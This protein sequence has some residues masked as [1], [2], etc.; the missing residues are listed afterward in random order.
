M[1]RSSKQGMALV[2]VLAFIV[3]VTGLVAAFLSRT[4]TVRQIAHGSFNNAKADHLARS[5]LDI[6]VADFKQ[7]IASGVPITNSTIVPQRSPKP[8]AGSTPAIA[9][10]I[11]R[12]VRAD[13]IPAPAVSSR[14][15]AANS[16]ADV[17]VNGRSVSLARWNRHY[18]VPKTN[19][20]DDAS[21]P[22]TPGFSAPDY[23]APD[24]VIVTRSGPTV[25]SGWNSGLADSTNASYALGRYAYAVYDEGGLLDF[26][27]AGYPYPSPSPAVTPAALIMN[28][29]R[30]GVSAFADLTAMKITFAG[31]TPNPTAVTKMVA[32]RN[33]ATLKASGTFPTLSPTPDPAASDFVT[34]SLKPTRDFL[35]VDATLYNNRTDQA[36]LSRQHLID[37]FSAVGASFNTLQFLGTFSREHNLPTWSDSATRLVGRFPLSRFDLFT[38]PTGNVTDIRR[39]FGVVYVAASRDTPEHWQYFGAQGTGLQASIQGLTGNQQDPDLSVL[40]RYAYPVTTTDGEILSIIASLIDQQDSDSNTT[41]IEYGDPT[42]PTKAF[43]ADSI[44]PAN[45]SDP[46]P[47]SSP[48]VLK[49][50]F[51][52]VGELGYAYRNASTTLDF[53]SAGSPDAPLLDLFTYNTA[54]TRAGIVNLNSQNSAVLAA[55]IQGAISNETTTAFVGEADPASNK[56]KTAYAAATA[57]IANPAD[58]TSVNPAIGRQD[59]SRLVAAAGTA[60]GSIEEAEETVARALAEVSQT[61]TWGL[62]I[63]VIAQSGRYPPSATSLAQFVVEGEKRYWLHVAIDR[64]TSEIIDQQLEAVYE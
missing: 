29:G 48:I 28:R 3:L 54:A 11:R 42:A 7:E 12:S 58:G 40:L 8:A 33:Y 64:F 44:P 18:L 31:A 25:F 10:L 6:I 62:M 60:I 49:R 63:D 16:T 52:N 4:G 24:W 55:L 45:P 53:H 38:N 61:R 37:L 41:W 20:S 36:F 17:S 22:I 50:P 30:K 27:V 19:P 56:S 39:Y 57:I 59:V 14:A 5:A 35:T 1:L 32:W 21:D 15:S 46:R 43:G 34:Y 9:N 13:A 26:N 23:W 51:R 47:S 2:V